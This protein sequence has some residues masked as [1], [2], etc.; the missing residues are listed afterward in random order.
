MSSKSFCASPVRSRISM[1]PVHL[2]DEP[3]LAGTFRK[4]VKDEPPSCVEVS[5][6][7]LRKA[8]PAVAQLSV[9]LHLAGQVPNAL[10]AHFRAV[11]FKT[12][13]DLLHDTRITERCS[14]NLHGTGASKHELNGVF[15][16]LDAAAADNGNPHSPVA[17]VNE[18]YRD[19]FD[20]GAGQAAHHIAE[21]R[22]AGCNVNGHA[23]YR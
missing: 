3:V 11:R 12:V 8:Q 9:Q 14:T 19:R 10:D 20:G 6:R 13:D 23:K 5:P 16:V 22:L 1:M 7:L 4:A 18:P 2:H 21:L 17:L 15:G